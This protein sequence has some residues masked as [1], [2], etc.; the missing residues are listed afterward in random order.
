MPGSQLASATAAAGASP[1]SM[2]ALLSSSSGSR[3]PRMSR[4]STQPGLG[5][6]PGHLPLLCTTTSLRALGLYYEIF[7]NKNCTHILSMFLYYVSQACQLKFKGINRVLLQRI[8]SVLGMFML[9]G[10]SVSL[11]GKTG[12]LGMQKWSSRIRHQVEGT[13]RKSSNW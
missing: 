10:K 3:Y 12:Q 4:S 13:R 9:K 11:G 6:L 2:P 1:A 5:L 7:T 8:P